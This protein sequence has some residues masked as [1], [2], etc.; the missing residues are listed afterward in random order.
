MTGGKWFR[1]AAKAGVLCLGAALWPRA[2]HAVGYDIIFDI[3]GQFGIGGI[4]V[5]AIIVGIISAAV[6]VSARKREEEL[7]RARERAAEHNRKAGAP[8]ASW[9]GQSP[10][11]GAK[12]GKSWADMSTAELKAY[13][14]A[15]ETRSESGSMTD[16]EKR[17]AGLYLRM[18]EGWDRGEILRFKYNFTPEAWAEFEKRLQAEL[19]SGRRTRMKNIAVSDVDAIV[20][21]DPDGQKTR[22]V[23]IKSR[24]DRWVEGPDGA[25]EGDTDEYVSMETVWTMIQPDKDRDEWVI[26]SIGE[27]TAQLESPDPQPE[28][29]AMRPDPSDYTEYKL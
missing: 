25:P 4:I 27:S 9:S 23:T 24:F 14:G 21:T 16:F 17:M 19:G 10:R 6:S 12:S 13:V 26:R 1:R 2:A 7:Q 8:G 11:V 22:V 15:N 5:A 3:A 28:S 20:D 18:Q 29:P